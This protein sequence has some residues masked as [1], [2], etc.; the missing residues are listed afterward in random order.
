MTE[1]EKLMEKAGVEY[2][3][4][5]AEA[6][7]QKDAPP[8]IGGG[9]PALGAC[10]KNSDGAEPDPEQIAKLKKGSAAAGEKVMATPPS[11]TDLRELHELCRC[12]V[13]TAFPD[14]ALRFFAQRKRLEVALDKVEKILVAAANRQYEAGVEVEGVKF[15]KYTPRKSWKYPVEVLKLE[16]DLKA[17]RKKA[18]IDGTAEE[19]TKPADPANTKLFSVKLV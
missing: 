8:L 3:P 9:G 7:G 18:Q 15:G 6:A 16:E 10:A 5:G 11:E 4:K 13:G 14:S 1:I 19:T 12:L 2:T 17:A